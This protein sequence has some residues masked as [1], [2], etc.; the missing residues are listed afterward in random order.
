MAQKNNINK[1]LMKKNKFWHK[2][3]IYECK[4]ILMMMLEEKE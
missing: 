4:N 1:F 3:K 2:N